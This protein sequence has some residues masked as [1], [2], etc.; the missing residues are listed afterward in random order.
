MGGQGRLQRSFDVGCGRLKRVQRAGDRGA[1]FGRRG[2]SGRSDRSGRI[3]RSG[4]PAGELDQLQLTHP[5]GF[6]RLRNLRKRLVGVRARHALRS[7]DQHQQPGLAARVE[8][9]APEQRQTQRHQRGQLQ[10]QRDPGSGAP[11]VHSTGPITGGLAAARGC[12]S[13]PGLPAARPSRA[14][15]GL[16]S[17]QP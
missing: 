16:A 14:A 5:G 15:T 17:R 2:R 8:P 9:R 6:C 3:G 4:R 1:W 7:I 12:A 13:C 10:C 11:C